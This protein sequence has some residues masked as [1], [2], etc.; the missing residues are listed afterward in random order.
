MQ[1]LRRGQH[2]GARAAQ[3]NAQCCLAAAGGL[4]HELRKRPPRAHLSAPQGAS[5]TRGGI[6]AGELGIVVKVKG[7]L[8]RLPHSGDEGAAQLAV[9]RAVRGVVGGLCMRV[10]AEVVQVT[11]ELIE[12]AL[13]LEL[14]PLSKIHHRS[15]AWE[16]AAFFDVHALWGGGVNDR[17]R[18]TRCVGA[19]ICDGAG[20][21]TREHLEG[22]HQLGLRRPSIS[23]A[24]L[25][26]GLADNGIPVAMKVSAPQ[27]GTE[28][29]W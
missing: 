13:T 27:R 15:V 19:D 4:L 14:V 9:Q 8:Q 18:A 20:S 5:H 10:P 7:R 17:N 6:N 24:V 21:R 16:L 29:K 25:D 11:H 2:R 3:S 22:Q 28:C 23:F 1:L 12:E 26:P